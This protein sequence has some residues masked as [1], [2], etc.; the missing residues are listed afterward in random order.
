MAHLTVRADIESLNQCSAAGVVKRALVAA[1]I[2]PVG[3]AGAYG[4]AIS[5]QQ[6]ARPVELEHLMGAIGL[7]DQHLTERIHNA[8]LGSLVVADP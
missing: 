3:A 8:T 5:G 7:T 1:Q 2:D 4:G 6:I